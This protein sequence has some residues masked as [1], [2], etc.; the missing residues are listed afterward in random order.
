MPQKITFYTNNV[1]VVHCPVVGHEAIIQILRMRQPVLYK[2]TV[3]HL[4]MAAWF[5]EFIHSISFRPATSNAQI[6][7]RFFVARQ[8][9]M[10]QQ[11]PVFM[12]SNKLSWVIF[13]LLLKTLQVYQ[14]HNTSRIGITLKY[15]PIWSMKVFLQLVQCNMQIKQRTILIFLSR[16]VWEFGLIGGV[17]WLESSLCGVWLSGKGEFGGENSLYRGL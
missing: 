9:L 16:P 2:C 11:S 17:F 1:G 8:C 14:G 5:W 7:S 3:N 4:K 10:S 15:E 12:Q 13:K 6:T